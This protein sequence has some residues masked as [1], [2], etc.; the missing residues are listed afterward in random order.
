MSYITICSCCGI[1]I[2]EDYH[3]ANIIQMY[4]HRH[5]NRG[6]QEDDID[7][8]CCQCYDNIL[9]FIKSRKRYTTSQEDVIQEEEDHYWHMKDDGIENR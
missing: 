7:H 3:P 1:I 4:D 2:D 9:D 6:V 8:L 5:N